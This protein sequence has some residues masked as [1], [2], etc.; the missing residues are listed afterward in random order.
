MSITDSINYPLEIIPKVRPAQVGRPRVRRTLDRVHQRVSTVISLLT[1]KAGIAEYVRTHRQKMPRGKKAGM[2]QILKR[3]ATSPHYSP[4]TSGM[5]PYGFFC[6]RPIIGE[7]API[8]GGIYLGPQSHEA[9]VVDSKYEAVQRATEEF[10]R[11]LADLNA[12]KSLDD[13]Q[14]LKFTMKYV[15]EILTLD[16]QEVEKL[17]RILVAR[18]DQKV[19]LDSYIHAGCAE[20]RHMVLLAGFL[21]ERCIHEKLAVGKLSF[22]SSQRVERLIYTAR[23]GTL[24]IVDFTKSGV[25]AGH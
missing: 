7:D 13:H 12:R 6:G 14:L 17:N 20:P 16:P 25:E 8:A 22:D 9:L 18:P 4:S 3:L 2:A 23:N 19:A 15:R 1:G 21:I 5:A 11:R 10:R 24:F